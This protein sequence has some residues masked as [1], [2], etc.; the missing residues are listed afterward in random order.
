MTI[1]ISTY[2]LRKVDFNEEQIKSILSGAAGFNS[3]LT[4]MTIDPTSYNKI[5]LNEKS[6]SA[7]ASPS[8]RNI[9]E[10]GTINSLLAQLDEWNGSSSSGNALAMRAAETIRTLL[11]REIGEA[12]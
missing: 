7:F 8:S 6:L 1:S 2:T 12:K 4:E 5:T 3:R 10:Q 11:A 9:L